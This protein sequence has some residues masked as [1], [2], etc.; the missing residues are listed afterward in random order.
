[1]DL[2]GLGFSVF[3]VTN[4]LICK[5]A[6]RKIVRRSAI[7]NIIALALALTVTLTHTLN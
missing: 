7:N 5:Q 6:P 4:N 1:M 3:V 2:A